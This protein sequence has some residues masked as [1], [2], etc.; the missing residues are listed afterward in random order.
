LYMRT[1]TTD[2]TAAAI[3]GITLRRSVNVARQL[4]VLAESS[5]D[6]GAPLFLSSSVLDPGHRIVRCCDTVV[7]AG[8]SRT[9]TASGA[10]SND[11]AEALAT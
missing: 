1:A 11:A 9:R 6:S 10:V 2:V 5:H 8:R 7:V 3:E 4:L